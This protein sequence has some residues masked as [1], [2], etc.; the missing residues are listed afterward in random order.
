MS[1]SGLDFHFET[2]LCIG[3]SDSHLLA[4]AVNTNTAIVPWPPETAPSAVDYDWVGSISAALLATAEAMTNGVGQL[5]LPPKRMAYFW[6]QK[7]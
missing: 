7:V 6:L 5:A 1:T 2:S 3:R 4:Q